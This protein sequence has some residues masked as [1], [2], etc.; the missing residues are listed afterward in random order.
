MLDANVSAQFK[1]SNNP[2]LTGWNA[3]M[4]VLDILNQLQDTYGKPSMM[5]L[6]T[7]ETLYRSPMVPTN[8]PEMLFYRIEQCQEN[9]IIGK[10]LFTTEQIIDN[11]VRLLIGLN[12]LPHKEFDT[13][14]AL[15]IKSWATLK[16]F[17]QEAYSRRLTPL[18]LRSTSGQN[19][20][21]NH[22]MYNVFDVL[23]DY[24]PNNDMVTTIAPVTSVAAT[25]ATMNSTLGMAPSAMPSVNA[26]IAAAINQLSANQSAIMSHMAALSSTPAPANPTTRCT[27]AVVPPIQQLAVL[28]AA[29]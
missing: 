2:N 28:A 3:T 24:N 8:S 22:N 17:I 13:W 10:V 4:S 6:F 5:T 15:P 20:Y 25:A 11:A 21:A 29:A 18:S 26:E 9:Q 14:K 23:D 19:G 27:T 1:V 16:T 12:L 7:N